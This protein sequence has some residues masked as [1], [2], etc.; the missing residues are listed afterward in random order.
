MNFCNLG[1]LDSVHV[2]NERLVTKSS[3]F[4]YID[5]TLS[6][7]KKCLNS[8]W[9]ASLVDRSWNSSH[10]HL[11]H[12]FDDRGSTVTH[13]TTNASSAISDEAMLRMEGYVWFLT[14]KHVY[15]YL[16]ATIDDFLFC[17]RDFHIFTGKLQQLLRTFFKGVFIAVSRRRLPW[18]DSLTADLLD[19]GQSKE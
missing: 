1:A 3:W 9:R 5:N 6:M 13:V 16:L 12:L 17:S 14:Y 7:I 11:S 4:S 18:T 19:K 15:M 10:C 8:F 2:T